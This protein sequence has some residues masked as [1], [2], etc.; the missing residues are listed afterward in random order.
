[1]KYDG[2]LERIWKEHEETGHKEN[3]KDLMDILLKDIFVAGTGSSGE[4][5]QW[6]MS[7]LIN[8]PHIL[9]KLREEISSVVGTGRLVDESDIPNLP[10]LQAVV[11]ETL[12]L[13][14]PLAVTT[15]ECREHCKIKGYDIPQ[16]TMV[17]INLYSVMRDP[18]V[19][20]NPNEFRPERF[21]V[22]S[23]VEGHDNETTI[24]GR[25]LVDFVPFGAGRRGCP[26]SALAYNTINS[27]IASLVQCF[28]WKAGASGDEAKVNMEV[29]VGLSLAKAHSLVC[30]PVVLFNPFVDP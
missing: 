23:T 14:P 1:M 29:G 15:R 12:R 5:M 6:T 10:Y 3:E 20:D 7:E 24:K 28:D 4:V 27:T 2:I 11:K 9:K 25:N 17:A 8:N 21:L 13:Y 26:G 30:L 18:E 16:N 22:S 19:W